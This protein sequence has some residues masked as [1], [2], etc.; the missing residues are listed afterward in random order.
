MR[1]F[2]QEEK[3]IRYSLRKARRSLKRRRKIKLRKKNLRIQLQ[4]KSEE[5]QKEIKRFKN[6]NTIT[7]PVRL[8]L[9]DNMEDS[10]RF[11]N[12][13]ESNLK[14][15]RKVFVDLSD[16]ADIDYG[17]I[18]ALL[19][20]MF[21]FNIRR[22]PFNGNFP[23]N[24][25][26]RA[27]LEDSQFFDR[28]FKGSFN[29]K[30]SIKKEHQI[31]GKGNNNVI[32]ELGA[33]LIKEASETIWGSKRKSP[34]LQRV[35]IELMQNTHNHAAINE[36]EEYWWISINHNKKDKK[37]SFAFID[38]GQGIFR[39]LANKTSASKWFGWPEKL[40]QMLVHGTN[41]EIL[42]MLLEGKM[43]Q[44]VTSEPFR[45]KGL[46]GINLVLKRNQ[47]SN[48]RVLS[49]NVY[50]NVEQ[51]MYTLLKRDFSGTFLYWELCETNE[52][53]PWII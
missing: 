44:I 46:P 27:K 40:K 37:V 19:S 17:A 18:T 15:K 1:K 2:Y 6:F 22:I 43:H 24:K 52:N 51:N 29:I 31:I 7:A 47:I 3:Y 9:L 16:V 48:L 30:D 25:R 50:A 14:K 28:L 12:A 23:K 8:L 20:I 42:K 53:K 13:L 21:T 32:S 45:G 36:G 49:N 38:Y 11:L 4:G 33:T 39:S 26:V 34:G 10:I 35:L 41:E 5:Q